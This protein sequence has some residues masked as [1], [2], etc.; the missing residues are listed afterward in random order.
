MTLYL[1]NV[2]FTFKL[3]LLGFNFGPNLHSQDD[4]IWSWSYY[5]EWLSSHDLPSYKIW[6]NLDKC[7]LRYET[8]KFRLCACALWVSYEVYCSIFRQSTWVWT[9]VNMTLYLLNVIFTFKIA[10]KDSHRLWTEKGSYR[11]CT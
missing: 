3:T 9:K 6:T 7:L 5:K 4:V 11:L 1:L 10:G 2:I 8:E